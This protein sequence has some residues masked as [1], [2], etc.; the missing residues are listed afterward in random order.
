VCLTGPRSTTG[1][2][3]GANLGSF[4]YPKLDILPWTYQP[5]LGIQG[6]PKSFPN[7]FYLSTDPGGTPFAGMSDEG[8]YYYHAGAQTCESR[9]RDSGASNLTIVFDDHLVD[10]N[11]PNPPHDCYFLKLDYRPKKV[12]GVRRCRGI[13]NAW[14]YCMYVLRHKT[15]RPLIEALEDCCQGETDPCDEYYLSVY[16]D[17]LAAGASIIPWWA[18][19]GQGFIGAMTNET[20]TRLPFNPSCPYLNVSLPSVYYRN[21]DVHDITSFNEDLLVPVGEQKV[22]MNNDQQCN[23]DSTSVC[24]SD[25]T[26]S[27]PNDKASCMWPDCR[28]CYTV[29]TKYVA[30]GVPSMLD[31]PFIAIESMFQPGDCVNKF[32]FISFGPGSISV[33]VDLYLRYDP[34]FKVVELSLFNCNSSECLYPYVMFTNAGSRLCLVNPAV[35]AATNGTFMFG[36]MSDPKLGPYPAIKNVQTSLHDNS[37]NMYGIYYTQKSASCPQSMH[38]TYLLS[39]HLVH[40]PQQHGKVPNLD[41]VL[42]LLDEQICS[43]VRVIGLTSVDALSCMYEFIAPEPC[44]ILVFGSSKYTIIRIDDTVTVFH[45]DHVYYDKEGEHR[46]PKCPDFKVPTWT[47]KPVVWK[48]PESLFL[49]LESAI[50]FVFSLFS[51]S[52]KDIADTLLGFVGYASLAFLTYVSLSKLSPALSLFLCAFWIIAYKRYVQL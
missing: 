14:S 13:L 50:E 44:A 28:G 38:P 36:F 1:Q 11:V 48:V 18:T 5:L 34:S 12:C 19:T 7:A 33:T 47:G 32:L 43:S 20:R 15:C 16:N 29:S 30:N 37:F 49:M 26:Q 27:W 40:R 8:L 10:I 4:K 23:K 41:P 17:R 24:T 52:L 45:K 39:E 3:R 42:T 9:L 31:D 6:I 25:A 2:T 46:L 51:F 21:V 35:T 22:M